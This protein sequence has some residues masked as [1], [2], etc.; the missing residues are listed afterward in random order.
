MGY[1]EQVKWSVGFCGGY[2]VVVIGLWVMV[3]AGFQVVVGS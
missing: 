2:V 3:E 1:G